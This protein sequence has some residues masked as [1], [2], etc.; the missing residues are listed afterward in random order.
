RFGE[1]LGI[2][3]TGM[4][5]ERS[6][7][8]L[9]SWAQATLVGSHASGFLRAHRTSLVEL[10]SDG[11]GPPLALVHPVGGGVTCYRQLV[12]HLKHPVLGFEAIGLNGERSVTSIEEMARGYVTSLVETWP[13]GPYVMGGWSFGGCVALEMARVLRARG[14]DVPLVVLID[15]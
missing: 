5:Q 6:L 1:E 2:P 12:R 3:T 4:S 10:R 9:M 15:S 14:A 13:A 7:S 8:W 11:D